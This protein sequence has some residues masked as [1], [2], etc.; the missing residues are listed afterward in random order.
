MEVAD[1]GSLHDSDFQDKKSRQHTKQRRAYHSHTN[2]L[3]CRNS[4]LD[5][6]EDSIGEAFAYNTSKNHTMGTKHGEGMRSDSASNHSDHCEGDLV[7]KKTESLLH[8]Y[9]N[10]NPKNVERSEYV[11]SKPSNSLRNS[12]IS[13]DVEERGLSSSIAKVH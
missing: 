12:R 7:V 5:L 6:Y 3:P 9:D 2:H 8:C 11:K 1:F 13:V 10:V 4:S